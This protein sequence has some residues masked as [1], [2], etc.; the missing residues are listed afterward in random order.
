LAG[1]LVFRTLLWSL[2][3]HLTFSNPPLDTIELLSWGR[4]WQWGYA[5]HPPLP[6]W[7]A[8]AGW[9][10]FGGNL[11]GVYFIGYALIAVAVWSVWR[12]ARLVVPPR[13]ALLAA[14]CMEGVLFYTYWGQRLN[15][16]IALTAF[17]SLTTLFSYKAARDGRLS[18]WIAAG[19]CAGF[20]LLS[21]Y[22][23][24]FLLLPLAVWMLKDSRAARAWR[25]P[26]PYLAG[27]IMLLIVTPHL[28]WAAREGWP[29]LVY[30]RERSLSAP[31]HWYPRIVEP[32]L[33]MVYQA[34]AVL[35]LAAVMTWGARLKMQTLSNER[36]AM[37][38]FLAF[39]VGGP[40]ALHLALG[41]ALG[42][43]LHGPWGTPFWADLGL[44]LI[45]LFPLLPGPRIRRGMIIGLVACNLGALLFLT[46]QAVLWPMIWKEPFRTQFP[47]KALANEADL[48]WHERFSEPLPGVAGNRLLAGTVGIHAAGRPRVYFSTDPDESTS[49]YQ[50]SAERDAEKMTRRGGIL[51]WDASQ[52][53]PDLPPLLAERFPAAE[54][55]ETIRFN[56]TTVGFALLPPE[57][58]SRR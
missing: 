23:M 21:K 56:G 41:W 39:V 26:G 47:G 30:G 44:F 46:G 19:A 16:D 7:L 14:F 38:R 54:P 45:V 48:R 5:K 17:W 9:R 29:T 8:D 40:L 12:L 18:D 24:V 49:C 3:T 50:F 43:Q 57:G 52:H 1:W 4:D 13:D 31:T 10:M 15:H 36:R 11:F 32:A 42:L 37:A 25:R 34:V 28:V 58:A 22:T 2:V 20:G 53:S 6:A 51:V 35:P 55:L 33:F 27:L